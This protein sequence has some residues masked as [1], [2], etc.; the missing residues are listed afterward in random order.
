[1]MIGIQMAFGQTFVLAVR[2]NV[3]WILGFPLLWLLG[4]PL[5]Q[6]WSAAKAYRTTPAARGDRT[7]KFDDDGITIDGGL[8]SGRLEWP[9]IVRVVETRDLLLL[10]LGSQVAHFIPKVAFGSTDEIEH[11]RQ[12]VARKVPS[13]VSPLG[14]IRSPAA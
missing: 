3:G 4:M 9:A 6:R 12:L 10:V 11:F 14:A 7:F 2:N 13:R 8:S 5:Q 1:L